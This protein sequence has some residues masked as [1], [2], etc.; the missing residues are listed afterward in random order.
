MELFGL[1]LCRGAYSSVLSRE[2]HAWDAQ[3]GSE[4]DPVDEFGAEQLYIVYVTADGGVDLEHLEL[5]SY[6]EAVSILLQVG[7]AAGKLSASPGT[8]VQ[9][10]K[11]C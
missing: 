4:N 10:Q 3:H 9:L 6:E 5:R 8:C 7:A 11:S 1:G 2:W